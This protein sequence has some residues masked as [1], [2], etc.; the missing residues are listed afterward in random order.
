MLYTE[1]Q[2]PLPPHLCSS[3]S[4]EEDLICAAILRVSPRLLTHLCYSGDSGELLANLPLEAQSDF[5]TL[6]LN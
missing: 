1:C 6:L 4:G 3:V 2:P 5:T